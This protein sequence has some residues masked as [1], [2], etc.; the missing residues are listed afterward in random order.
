MNNFTVLRMWVVMIVVAGTWAGC[1]TNTSSE[2]ETT[3]TPDSVV[4][5]D[6]AAPDLN[7]NQSELLQ[8]IVGNSSE[9]VI[10]G[11]SFGDRVS[12][13]KASESFEMFEDTIDHVGFTLDTEQLETIDVQ[14]FYAQN[15][16]IN[17]IT[18]D[19]YLNSDAATR[20]LWNASKAH[21]SERYTAPLEDSPRRIVWKKAPV[22]LT[23]DNVSDGK[24]HGLKLT[25]EPTD[26]T[27]LASI[28]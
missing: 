12:K 9:G 21:F 14:Y 20:Q 24:D 6:P 19:V 1:R 7:S 10:R 8:T 18:V 13:V 11:I 4:L 22:L 23:L 2:E 26:K 5:S 17:K 25:F 15:K 3:A 16:R 27:V 28:R